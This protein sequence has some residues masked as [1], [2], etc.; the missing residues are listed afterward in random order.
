MGLGA[1]AR[2]AG[3]SAH[4]AAHGAAASAVSRRHSVTEGSEVSQD[5]EGSHRGSRHQLRSTMF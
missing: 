2:H 5:T 4:S 3:A 1:Y